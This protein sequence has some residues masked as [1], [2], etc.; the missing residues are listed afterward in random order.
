[1][2]RPTVLAAASALTL[3]LGC[4]LLAGCN[5]GS[6]SA[7]GEPDLLSI[8]ALSP[9]AG[10]TLAPGGPVTFSATLDYALNSS[11]AATISLV[12]AD[13]DGHVLNPDDEVTTVVSQGVGSVNLSARVAIPAA[14]VSQVRVSFQLAPSRAF[15]S[16]VTASASYAVGNG[17]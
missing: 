6:P 9:A 13:Q 14:G 2:N 12:A 1:M 15:S 3:A 4:A 10:T 5:S 16:Q 17:R 7:P 8:A 11:S